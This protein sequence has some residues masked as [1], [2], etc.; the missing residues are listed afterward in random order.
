MD[1]YFTEG[2]R[3]ANFLGSQV[4]KYHRTLTTYLNTLLTVGFTLEA[5][6]EPQPEP[7][8]LA[9]V[10]GMADELRRPMMLLVKAVKAV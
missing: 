9:E 1:H 4:T 5:V 3:Q 10:P 6:V 7:R 8:L 2:K